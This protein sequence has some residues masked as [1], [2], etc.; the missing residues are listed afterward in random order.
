MIASRYATGM[1]YNPALRTAAYGTIRPPSGGNALAPVY[2]AGFGVPAGFGGDGAAL[3][4][5]AAGGGLSGGPVPMMMPQGGAGGDVGDNAARDA[6]S[7]RGAPSTGS[8]LGDIEAA[9][10]AGLFG[11]AV[12]MMNP[13]GIV[14]GTLSA[15]TAGGLRAAG[16]EN[17]A[18][19]LFNAS[20]LGVANFGE[21]NSLGNMG[22]EPSTGQN[23]GGGGPNSGGN[24]S[25]PGMVTDPN[26]ATGAL[27]GSEFGNLDFGGLTGD[28]SG[29]DNGGMGN[30]GDGSTSGGG[31]GGASGEGGG[32][33]DGT[34]SSDPGG[35]AASGS[36]ASEGWRK[37]GYTGSGEDG[38]VDPYKEAGPA[39]EGEYVLRHEATRHYG[40]DILAALN[41]GAIPR[42]ALLAFV[43]QRRPMHAANHLVQMMMARG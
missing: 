27:L 43:P 23:L 11:A 4:G 20:V 37:G 16:L 7:E 15:L 36:N 3:S 10:D 18:R 42:N 35:S 9:Y 19:G 28:S 34:G 33:N 6:A 25:E 24:L 41:A 13:V 29:M 5:G 31:L 30:P 2:N 26:V 1:G 38:K 14:S 21:P 12:G 39:H 17:A 32:L 22:G 40:P 8:V